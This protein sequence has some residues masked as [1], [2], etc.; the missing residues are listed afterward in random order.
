MEGEKGGQSASGVS[1]L[2]LLTRCLVLA[3]RKHSADT[4]QN[5]LPS[6][7]N[8]TH[9][10]AKVGGTSVLLWLFVVVVLYLCLGEH[11]FYNK[12]HELRILFNQSER[13]HG[14]NPHL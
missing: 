7:A 12:K 3:A 5:R 9:L 10:E 14:G 1:C 13:R 8:L 2:V 6:T 11:L 4:W